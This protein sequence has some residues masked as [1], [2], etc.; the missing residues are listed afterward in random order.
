MGNMGIYFEEEHKKARW[1]SGQ[2]IL[3][4]E[5]RDAR[6]AERQKNAK[7][8]YGVRNSYGVLR[9]LKQED[10]RGREKEGLSLEAL[11]APGTPLH[12]EKEKHLDLETMKR[13]YHAGK[14]DLYSSELPLHSQALFYDTQNTKKSTHF[15]TCMKRLIQT[16]GHQALKDTFGFLDQEP[17]RIE[18]ELLKQGLPHTLGQTEST[19]SSH[20]MDT[21]NSRLLRKKAMERQLLGELQLMLGQQEKETQAQGQKGHGI[22]GMGQKKEKQQDTPPRRRIFPEIEGLDGASGQAEEGEGQ[23]NTPNQPDLGAN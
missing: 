20:R 8:T 18:L 3:H 2:A 12:T 22:E 9:Y 10:T 13:V 16:K 6:Q 23:E 17:E 19:E 14:Q 4:Q 5:T 7:E 1:E 11:E 15:L 21:L